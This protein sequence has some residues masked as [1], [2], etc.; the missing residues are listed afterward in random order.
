MF[1]LFSRWKSLDKMLFASNLA[2]VSLEGLLFLFFGFEVP[3]V[4]PV[5]FG[6]SLI[7]AWI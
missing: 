4:S 1:Y 5:I 3:W 6:V 7:G 2:P